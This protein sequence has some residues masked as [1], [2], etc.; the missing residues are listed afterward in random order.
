[1]EALKGVVPKVSVC[2]ALARPAT[3]GVGAAR[4]VSG[5][6]RT[7]AASR[8]PLTPPCLTLSSHPP[9][10]LLIGG[11]WVDASNGETYENLDPRT[12]DKLVDVASAQPEDVD[13]AVRAAR[14]AYDEGP[15]PR[16]SGYERG[17]IIFR[18]A[19]LLEVRPPPP[20]L[21]LLLL[22]LRG[23]GRG[24]RPLFPPC[25][26]HAHPPRPSV[27]QEHA[28]ELALLESLDNGKTLAQSKTIDV[29][30]SIQHIRY[31]AGLADKITGEVLP[32]A[33]EG[34]TAYTLREPMG[35]VGQIIPW[36]RSLLPGGLRAVRGVC[37]RARAGGRAGAQCCDCCP[38]LS[39]P[40]PPSPP[41]CC[42]VRTFPS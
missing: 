37:V 17:R 32:V 11:K 40:A 28:D 16:M 21:L 5:R 3:C 2:G 35:V 27:V 31:F 23:V 9:P 20:L 41:A 39:T 10:K 18:L 6:A 30:S 13:S 36:V 4:H 29:P 42:L 22:L 24:A 34:F 7:A 1:M 15:W 33:T 26:P 12:G 14:E 38:L 19:D 25:P 8:S